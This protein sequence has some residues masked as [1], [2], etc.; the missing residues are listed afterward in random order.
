[1]I[2]TPATPPFEVNTY[3]TLEGAQSYFDTRLNTE[4]WDKASDK[5]KIKALIMATRAIDNLNFSGC[6][7]VSTQFL[8]FPRN[9]NTEIP[10]AIEIA[11]CECALQFLDDVEMEA[12]I[13][14][15][16]ANSD[17]YAS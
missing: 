17:N 8:Q 9:R 2:G 5:N 1:M 6:K 11:T 3:I 7:S 10:T 16:R 12:E 13:T 15:L 4:A 14:G